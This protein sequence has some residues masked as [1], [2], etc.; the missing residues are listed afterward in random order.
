[1]RKLIITAL[2]ICIALSFHGP[3]AAA[4]AELWVASVRGIVSHAFL[5]DSG[6]ALAAGNSVVL[7]GND[8]K[9][10]WSWS[11]GS[12]IG[13]VTADMAGA[14]YA[15]YSNRLVKLGANGKLVWEKSTFDKAYALDVMEGGIFVGWEYG[16][17]KFDADGNLLWEYYR[18]E[19]C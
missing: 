12:P 19:D 5:P 9:Q 6:I 10:K 15:T 18:P 1:M 4:P 13:F 11:A 14:V 16:L 17:M 3:A 2:L 8:G 7:L